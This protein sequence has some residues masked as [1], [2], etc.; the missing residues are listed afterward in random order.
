MESKGIQQQKNRTGFGV[1]DLARDNATVKS[2]QKDEVGK[3][4]KR[5]EIPF[6]NFNSVQSEYCN[7]N[8][9]LS[10][11]S[12]SSGKNDLYG[13]SNH[14]HE[15]EKLSVSKLGSVQSESPFKI[16]SHVEARINESDDF[17]QGKILRA[18]YDGTFDVYCDNGKRLLGIAK[19]NIRLVVSKDV[20]KEEYS[21][22]YV[23]TTKNSDNTENDRFAIGTEVE[24]QYRGKSQFYSGKIIRCRY[25]GSYDIQYDDGDRE[26]G[27]PRELIR[28][29][30]NAKNLYH[31]MSPEKQ[32]DTILSIGAEVE[33]KYRGSNR[34]CPGKILRKRFDGT[35]DILYDDGERELGVSKSMIRMKEKHSSSSEDN[36]K[37][38]GDNDT[39]TLKQENAEMKTE[40][41]GL[42]SSSFLTS[43]NDRVHLA[44]TT[45]RVLESEVLSNKIDL[46]GKDVGEN[47]NIAADGFETPT[48]SIGDK[49]EAKFRGGRDYY[50]GTISAVL[51]SDFYSIAY[52]D[53]D[54]DER[55][56]GSNILL[57]SKDME[58]ATTFKVGDEVEAIFGGSSFNQYYPG[59]IVKVHPD[60]DTFDI[61]YHDGDK[62]KRVPKTLIRNIVV[63]D[64]RRDSNIQEVSI[65]DFVE[66]RFRGTGGYYPGVISM[67]HQDKT[68]DIDYDDGDKDKRIPLVFVKRVRKVGLDTEMA[69]QNDET[70]PV[71][72]EVQSL[73]DVKHNRSTKDIDVNHTQIND[74]L[75]DDGFLS[76]MRRCIE[77]LKEATLNLLHTHKQTSSSPLD[78]YQMIKWINTKEKEASKIISSVTH[79][80][81]YRIEKESFTVEEDYIE[82]LKIHHSILQSARIC[83][84]TLHETVHE[85]LD[86]AFSNFCRIYTKN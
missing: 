13:L 62:E 45:E 3:S 2:E 7:I 5:D 49:V 84:E 39:F 34:Y 76:E 81:C 32:I 83:K 9:Q 53:G 1:Q 69:Q 12:N 79:C 82:A 20:V 31:L 25:D 66:A 52:D 18:R 64:S 78:M 23:N 42:S 28:T 43:V 38:V 73:E 65:G 61:D 70:Q 47:V 21:A 41:A 57:I 27:V 60:N 35:F 24:A 8:P 22:T 36:T 19:E 33:A 55:L 77:T 51:G 80:L 14:Q 71:S 86:L 37:A 15:N 85:D 50:R 29:P 54:Y 63:E 58:S 46:E 4:S 6:D 56:S 10:L 26:L 59:T 75:H 11:R 67:V 40:K 68:V 30:V 16:G 74:S 44:S 72:N 17:T 48:F